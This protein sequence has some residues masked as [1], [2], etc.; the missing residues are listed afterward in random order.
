MTE[1]PTKT[2]A[3]PALR[4]RAGEVI[5]GKFRI[6]KEI[7]RGGMGV[8]YEAEDL[9]LGRK[10][11]LKFL[12]PSLTGD[13]AARERFVLEARTASGLDHANICTIHEIGETEGGEM[14][15]AMAFYRGESLRERLEQGPL[16]PAEALAIAVQAAE[17]LAKAHELG[18]VHR[19]VKP[20]NIF[21]T[22]DG[23]VKILDFGLAKLAGQ[24]KVT[25]PGSALGTAAYM[26]PEQVRGE[27]VGPETDIWSLGVVLYEMMAGALPFPG[28]NLQAVLH[29][30]LSEPPHPVKDLRP[31][32]PAGIES[33]VRRALAKDPA[34]RFPS[35]LRLAEALRA[36]G[37]NASPKTRST[38]RRLLFPRPRRRLALVSA[39]AALTLA[40]IGLGIWLLS[41]PSLAFESRDKLMVADVD[42][43]TGDEV[44]D[45]ALRTAIEADLEQS[46][47]AAIFDKPQIAETL[48]LMRMSPTS[49]V[50][51][52]VGCKVCRFAG[53][54]VLVVPRIL[55]AGEAYEL[56]AILVDPIRR[57]HVERIR[58]T[59]KGREDVLLHAIDELAGKLRS[60]LG[61]SLAS[62]EKADRPVARVTTSSWE[63]LNYFALG[64]ARW[65]E[66]K[67]KEAGSLLEL[68]LEK[69]PQF[70]EARSSLGLLDL[71]FL[72]RP[73]EGREMLRQALRDAQA[74]ELPEVDIL[75]L[76]AVNKQFVERDLPGALEAYAMMREVFP[77]FMPAWNNSGMMLRALGRSDE[78]VAMYEKAAELAPRNSIPLYN[79]WFTYLDYLRDPKAAE[80]VARRMIA[81]S[82]DMAYSHN[83]LGYSLAVQGRFE[84]AA[85]E[86]RRTVEIEPR[87]PYGLPN[88]AHVLLALGRAAEA[89]PL[90]REVYEM[91][92]QGRGT[93]SVENDGFDL[94]LAL[95]EAG[96]AAESARVAGECRKRIIEG[97]GGRP[98]DVDDLTI[99][100]LLAAAAGDSA[101]A[102]SNLEQV[103][104]LEVKDPY[105]LMNI[106][107]LEAL[108]GRSREALETMK[109]SYAAG[110][111]D[112]F[113][114][115]V[116]PG[117]RSL[118]GDPEFRALLKLDG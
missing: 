78:A 36:L 109:K 110:Y 9:K 43:Q 19:D 21:L 94:A 45:L 46:P 116:L 84:E 11:A 57:R 64:T 33:L 16:P 91:A 54:R 47:Y 50:D 66:A 1:D 98:S 2:I 80:G 71:Q 69:D 88:L 118:R 22:A 96:D 65:G 73:D 82:P 68:A 83:A 30:I 18:I 61:E 111:F 8:V 56:Q 95:R 89:V 76:K 87:H 63:A 20:G 14:F 85:E 29:G 112:Y 23:T 44:F 113:F 6:V 41:R 38:A 52:D 26:S 53:V 114:P 74:Q 72:G 39:A 4:A 75:K 42:N 97:A 101:R 32:F 15:I 104:K 12:P 92:K 90:Y 59:A 79:L 62:I 117:F 105:K 27:E 60:R 93:G 67:F 13:P 5:A 37:A 108:L 17:G 10:V 55:S 99:L 102:A 28:G 100:G 24:A 40:G 106:A 31:G 115:V 3:T 35:A 86:L 107:T 70:V 34:K 51:E 77:D 7:G 58:V 103:R 48:K 49:K 25:A 81:L